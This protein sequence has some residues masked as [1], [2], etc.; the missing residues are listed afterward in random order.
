MLDLENYGLLPIFLVGLSVIVAGGEVGHRVGLRI[1]VRD[2][3]NVATLEGAVLGLLALMLGFTF[4]MALSLFES[5]REVILEE[6]NAIGTAALRARLLPAPYNTDALKLLREYVQIRIDVSSGG[7]TPAKLDAAIA[8]SDA[9]HEA[10]WQQAK[11]AAK[12]DNAMVPTGLYI[13]VLNETIDAQQK[14][15]T[16]IGYRVPNLVI[17]AL[18]AV[19]AVSSAF[20][21]Y[22]SALKARRWRIPVY[23]MGV[24]VAAVILL[25]QDLERPGGYIAVSQ[26]PMIDTAAILATYTD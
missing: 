20:A 2:K 25:I 16:T 15:V 8:R 12:A 9:L 3:D 1:G 26:Q 7:P 13:Q 18:Y 22:S 24:L 6:A 4:A 21:G 17:I 19:A 14:R 11:A 5:R 23:V 10:L